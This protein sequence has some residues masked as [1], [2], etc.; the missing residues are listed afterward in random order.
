MGSFAVNPDIGL[1]ERNAVLNGRNTYYVTGQV[2]GTLSIKTVLNGEGTWATPDGR[3]RLDP[4]SYLVLNRGQTYG[5][6][7]RSPETVETFCAFF[8]PGFVE[9]IAEG[10]GQDWAGLLE[11]GSASP[12]ACFYERINPAD[13]LV[14][15]EMSHLRKLVRR[16]PD[17][18]IEA[19]ETMI[20]LA[21]A[22]LKSQRETR[23]QRDGLELA[24]ASTREEIYRRL[25]VARDFMIAHLDQATDLDQI[26][27]A[28][29]LSPFHFH[30]LFKNAFGMTPHDFIVE[31]RVERSKRL[32]ASSSTPMAEIAWAVG[33]ESPAAFS[34][35]FSRWQGVSP[36]AFRK[37]ASL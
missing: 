36:S 24:R 2:E 11:E 33:F 1:W 20:R 29:N 10:L 16:G 21:I 9:A 14:A 19:E 30:R 35:F 34:K 13:D 26:A 22:L 4:G 8:R 32:L 12:E 28:A 7:I 23:Q 6:D 25:N 17:S 15:Q 27:S 18:E 5:V 37:A 31:R 3:Y